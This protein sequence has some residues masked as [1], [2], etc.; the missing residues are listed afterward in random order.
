MLKILKKLFYKECKHEW[1]IE[2]PLNF[3]GVNEKSVDQQL[4]ESCKKC[5]EKRIR[6]DCRHLWC[7]GPEEN[8]VN[9]IIINGLKYQKI[10]ICGKC[11][12]AKYKVVE[13]LLPYFLY[14]K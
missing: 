6:P 5:G 13:W 10:A 1:R 8:E 3:I 9:G 7:I 14:F 2:D 4:I 11:G 12:L